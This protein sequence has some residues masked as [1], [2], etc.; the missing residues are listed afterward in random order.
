MRFMLTAL[1][2]A[3]AAR[4]S[5]DFTVVSKNT[6]NGSPAGNTTNY[7]S[8]NHARMEQR[9]HDVIIDVK[10]GTMTILDN[11]KKTWYAVT[12]ADTDELNARM[13]EKM[14]SPE[15][16]KGMEAMQGMTSAMASNIE[17]K[18]TGNSRKVGSYS[19][20]E[21]EIT[22]NAMTTMKECVTSE[23]KF[24]AHAY[25]AFRKFGASMSGA[26]PFAPAAKAGESLGEKMAAIKGY[27]VATSMVIDVMGNKTT[28]TSEV[29]EIS[30][31]A[32]PA[33][34][35]EVPAGYTQIE[36]PMKKAFDHH[37]R[38]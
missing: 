3:S 26:S 16:K 15:A 2:F 4:G 14:S 29:I 33:S 36:N 17:V 8:E 31:A 6:L 27:P 5:E 25:E 37:G 30:H 10:S 9:G 32:I 21:W 7:L 35:W 34:T 18:K 20:D 19:C 22:M 24:P 28:T 1:L 13:K 23:V 11:R 12:K 38:D